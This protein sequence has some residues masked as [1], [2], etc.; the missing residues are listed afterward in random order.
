MKKF[1]ASVVSGLFVL[2]T[3]ASSFA[4]HAEIPSE[5]QAVVAKGSTQIT[6]GGE[7][8]VRGEYLNNP[9]TQDDS[10][11][12]SGYDERVRL[13]LE[14]KV[15]PNTTGFVMLE[16]GGLDLLGDA[17]DT[18]SW[19][20]GV[21]VPVLGA[22][23]V[24]TEGAT[25]IW[26]A[27]NLKRG[28][29]RLLEAWILHTGSGLLGIPAGVKVG[30]MPLALGNRLFFDH[31]KFGDDAIVFFMDPTKE[32]H[33]GLLTI[34]FDEGNKGRSDDADAYVGLVSYKPSR[35]MSFS[36][37]VTYVDDQQSRG[38]SWYLGGLDFI[39]MPSGSFTPRSF[40]THLW[41]FDLRGNME[42][43]GGS[44]FGVMAD[45]ELQT[46][47]AEMSK[48]GGVDADLN[49]WAAQ[50][51]VNYDMN[52]VKLS[53]TYAYGSGGDD[54]ATGVFDGDGNVGAFVTSLGSDQHYTYVYE[55]RVQSAVGATGSGLANTT[56]LKLG[57]DAELAKDLTGNFGLYWLKA[58]E[59]VSLNGAPAD[60]DLG[61]E[62]DAKL[63]YN[64]DR[65]LKYWV[66]GGVFWMGDAYRYSP[67]DDADN[68]YAV[69][70]GIQL[71]F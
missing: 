40:P 24:G 12:K 39:T 23:P 52:P 55:Y 35:D 31:T 5:S 71:S 46:G 70:H 3:A 17:N 14:A 67:T 21:T 10:Q 65:N 59:D 4:I 25:G 20:D 49:G 68:A 51:G 50:I 2:G 29:L 53:L 60:D 1:L 42:D 7:I 63:T 54:N 34:K 44:G 47:E 43:L 57:A 19:G 8:R 28:D 22:T 69:R 64:I 66:E 27:G 13:S 26:Q 48:F 15:T 16:T 18:F 36:A 37:D 30:H 33:A 61:W 56:Y 32:L 11:H 9:S 38:L 6:L 41:N 45:V 62:L 58:S